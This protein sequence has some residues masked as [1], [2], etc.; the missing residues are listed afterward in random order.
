[1]QFLLEGWAI[2]KALNS[3]TRRVP[4]SNVRKKEPAHLKEMTSGVRSY[5]LSVKRG[6]YQDEFSRILIL[7]ALRRP[8][9]IEYPEMLTL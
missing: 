7:P 9:G 3:A 8:E 5:R 1:M 4:R 2:V 6:K